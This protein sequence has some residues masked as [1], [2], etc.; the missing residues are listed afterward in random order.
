M[1]PIAGV[2]L[3][4]L[5][6]SR[7]LYTVASFAG[8]MKNYAQLVARCALV[9]MI[10]GPFVVSMRGPASL[11]ELAHIVS[12]VALIYLVVALLLKAIRNR[13]VRLQAALALALCLAE[14]LPGMPRLHAAISPIL[15]AVLAWAVFELAEDSQSAPAGGFGILLIPGLVLIPILYGVGYRHQTSGFLLHIGTALVIGGFFL[16]WSMVLKEHHQDNERLRNACNLMITAILVQ[17]VLGVAAFV[18]RLIEIENGL[19]LAVTRTL[20]ITGAAVVI[21][22]ASELAIQYRRRTAVGMVTAWQK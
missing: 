17:I 3:I 7:L 1:S 19:L 22:A 13:R 4:G 14:A 11:F 20:H 8:S 18:I 12:G 15:F 5:R 16:M 6:N 21:A 2:C 9:P 10:S